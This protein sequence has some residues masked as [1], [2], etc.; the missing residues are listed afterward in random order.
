[1]GEAFDGDKFLE[2]AEKSYQEKRY[3]KAG[4]HLLTDDQ[5]AELMTSYGVLH[6]YIPEAERKRREAEQKAEEEEKQHKRLEATERIIFEKEEE[7]SKTT[8]LPKHLLENM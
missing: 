1:F 2:K 8:R 6:N 3:D 7:T 4:G 5:I